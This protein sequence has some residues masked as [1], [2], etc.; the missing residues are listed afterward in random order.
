MP[1]SQLNRDER[2]TITYLKML[3]HSPAEIGRR[4][5]RHRGTITREIKRNPGHALCG[6]H[7]ESA[8]RLA[9]ERRSNASR[10]YKLDSS[11]PGSDEVSELGQY[12]RDSLKEG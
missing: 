3:G 1:R 5:G 6:Y 10:R 2:R 11:S 12:V 8:Q 4:L 9:Q 7:Y